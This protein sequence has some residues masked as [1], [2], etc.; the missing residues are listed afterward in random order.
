MKQVEQIRYQ[1]EDGKTFKSKEA[2]E[3]YEAVGQARAKY[4]ADVDAFIEHLKANT[5]A[6][7]ADSKGRKLAEGRIRNVVSQYLAFLDAGQA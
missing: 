6:E 1:A 4:K 7:D 5:P 3:Q 2:C